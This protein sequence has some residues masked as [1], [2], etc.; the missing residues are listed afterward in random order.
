MTT[1][2]TGATGLVGNNVVRAL[3]AQGRAVRVLT[4]ANSDPR[5]LAGLDVEIV[6][7]DVRDAVAV[8]KSVQGVNEVVHSAAYVHIGWQGTETA[9]SINVEG[10]RNMSQAAL[11]AGA[12]MV[13]VSSVDAL[14]LASGKRLAN[15][16]TPVNGGVLSPYVVT[17]RAAEAVVLEQVERGLPATIVNP[18]FMIGPYDWKP[19]SGRMLLQVAKGWG[20]F[21]PLGANSYCDVR[22]VTA[23]ILAAL[24]R[25]LPG[26]KYI[27]AGEVL[28]YFQAWRT[29][30]KVTGATPPLVPIGPLARKV[31]GLAGD[32][33]R[34]LT[35][36]EPDVNSATTAISAQWRGFSSAR[37]EAELSY[38]SR[39]IEESV[40]DAWTWFR[41]N[42]YV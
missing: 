36:R 14:G 39:P 9:R 32:A 8:E 6:H 31:A 3:L 29:I 19:S 17:K 16:E 1:L 30:A 2:V 21:A 37:A 10:T 23:G 13:H 41:A 20:L 4:R 34:G 18:G 38:R 40:A 7:G 22:D 28:T 35:G 24:D 15:E 12:K 42:G 11:R 26:R 25:G 33:W 27:L 5:P